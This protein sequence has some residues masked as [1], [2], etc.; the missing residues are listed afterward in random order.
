MLSLP[1]VAEA[2]DGVLVGLVG[3]DADPA[4]SVDSEGLKRPYHEPPRGLTG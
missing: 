4:V 3:E 1:S 2:T